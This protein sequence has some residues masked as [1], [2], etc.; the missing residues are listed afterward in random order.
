MTKRQRPIVIASEPTTDILER[1]WSDHNA[2]PQL[3]L[4][5][6]PGRDGVNVR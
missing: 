5:T 6:A 2:S 1:L 4:H 3:S